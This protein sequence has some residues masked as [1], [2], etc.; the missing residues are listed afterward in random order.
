MASRLI[1]HIGLQK[2]GT[3]YLQELIA[4]SAGELAEAGIVYPV[5]PAGK[6][7]RR[8]DNHEWASYGL[9]G[10]EYPWVSE[11]RAATE[12]SAWKDLERQ[13]SRE[14]GTV[15]L[16]AEALSVIRTPAIR[17]L[18]ARLGVGDVEVV[19]TARS[20]G[21]SLP[22]LWQQHV[23]N[24]RR[25]GFERYLDMLG[26]Q[27][28][29]PAAR[30]E[31]DGELH[32]WR[33]FAIGRLARRWAR[34]VGQSRVRVVTSPGRPPQLLWARF[35]EAIG[36]PGFT[37]PTGDAAARPVHTGLTA[38]EAVVLTSLNSALAKAGWT[39]DTARRLREAVL[40]DGFQPRVERGP[41]IA[42]PPHWRS[43]VAE[44][45]AQDVS[46]L[47]ESGVTV[48]GDTA[49]LRSDRDDV[50]PPTIEEVAAA[51]AA[52]VLAVGAG[53]AMGA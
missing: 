49:D 18:L 39:P 45:S 19:V 53:K 40:A 10:Q 33:A 21:R 5:A 8:T 46:E 34:E 24:G 26:E 32:L 47:L 20:L 3:T 9:L 27:R 44:W 16:S 51:S 43:C 23:R 25:L 36:V 7:R 28:R 6:R 42:V 12:K 14:K 13:V 35:A 50:Q 31:E 52:A 15:L 17:T 30:I 22:S 38:P 37:F 48:I 2:S 1:L 4:G 11:E 41:R 29:L